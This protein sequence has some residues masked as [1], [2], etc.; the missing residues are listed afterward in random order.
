MTPRDRLQR[1]ADLGSKTTRYW[2]LIAVFAVAGAALSLAFVLLRPKKYTSHAVLFYQ[3]RIQTSLL[4]NREEVVQRNIGDRY[5]ELLLARGQLETIIKDPKLNPYPDEQDTDLAIDKLRMQIKFE[6]RGANAFRINYTDQDPDRAKAVT[7]KLTDL[8]QKKDEGLRNEQAKATASFA[9]TQ[10]D[11]AQAGLAKHELSL[12]SF[13][14][15]HPEF[16]Q[17]AQQAA[18]AGQFAGEGAS[19]RSLR[20][21]PKAQNTG[22]ARLYALERQKRRIQARLDA[23]PDAPPIRIPAP[24]TPEKIAAEQE[25]SQA[26]SELGA[27]NRELAEALQQYTDQHPAAIRARDRVAN[28]QAK[29]KKAQASVPPDVET[30]V[31]PAT[32]ADRE[33]LRKELATLE[34]QIVSE[35]KRD[36]KAAVAVDSTT[37][38]VVQ[39]ETEHSKLRRT[40]LE[41]RERVESLADSVFRAQ[42]DANQKLAE[43]GGRLSVVDPAFK[44]VKPSGPGKTLLMLAGMALF[45]AL[46]GGLAVGMAVIDDRLYRRNDLDELGIHVLA[47]IPPQLS[48]SQLKKQFKKGQAEQRKGRAA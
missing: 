37:D 36:P 47:V 6:A 8:L 44:P 24:Q 16:A 19:I 4:S 10:K 9:V 28:A 18:A 21:K 32:E 38:W 41:E 17:D 13:L 23:P 22:N 11:E 12:A 2:W 34:G 35:Q 15:K 20:D 46:G 31:A 1:I 14:A 26:R 45:L 5:R 7:E 27:A 39:L 3:E 43:S 25:V 29:L 33:K 30:A 40:V 48:K 42:M